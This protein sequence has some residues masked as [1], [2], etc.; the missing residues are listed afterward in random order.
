MP[1][2][3]QIVSGIRIRRGDVVLVLLYHEL[4]ESGW[5]HA[6]KHLLEDV[7]VGSVH[8]FQAL[9][10]ELLNPLTSTDPPLRRSLLGRFKLAPAPL[11]S[12][13][14]LLRL[15]LLL[16]LL[17]SL[18][19]LP[20]VFVKSDDSRPVYVRRSSGC[21]WV[22]SGFLYLLLPL[23]PPLF[24]G[25]LFR[26]APCDGGVIEKVDDGLLDSGTGR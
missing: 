20:P 23:L 15:L 4:E 1:E 21:S 22:R 2:R 26:C 14:D 17:V 9:V 6:R 7:D 12:N 5:C 19:V 10:R 18:P 3:P 16:L 24:S 13:N 25:R 8:L 11:S